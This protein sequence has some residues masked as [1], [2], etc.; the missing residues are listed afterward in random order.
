M[1]K[2][3]L[4]LLITMVLAAAAA[5]LVPHAPNFTPVAS[6]A[7]FGGACFQDKRMAF[8]VPVAALLL[9][10]LFLGFH[11]Y[12]L[13]VYGCFLLTVCI[14]FLLKEQRGATRTLGAVVLSTVV[15]FVV[16]NFG[17]WSV[18]TLYPHTW[19]GL[20]ECFVLAVPFLANS[21]LGNLVYAGVLFG[22]LALAEKTVPAL[23]PATASPTC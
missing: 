8:G 20:T 13:W 14:G 17:V 10:D 7:L 4:F 23:K 12:L 19:A 21:F 6:M 16:T 22:G 5:R 9:S 11:R 1:S 2:S 3:R 15:F 18:G